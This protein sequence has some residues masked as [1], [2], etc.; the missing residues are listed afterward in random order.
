MS[1]IHLRVQ[2]Q[3]EFKANVLTITREHIFGKILR[4]TTDSLYLIENKRNKDVVIEGFNI[5]TLRIK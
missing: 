5:K 4:I 3:N 2:G 1:Y